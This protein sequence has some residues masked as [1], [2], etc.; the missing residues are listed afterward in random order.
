LGL[1]W[2]TCIKGFR[3]SQLSSVRTPCL[4]SVFIC[5]LISYAS[6]TN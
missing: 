3:S 5:R 4:L 2:L 1:T 6:S